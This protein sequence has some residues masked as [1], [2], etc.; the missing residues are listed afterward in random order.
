M[1]KCT[2]SFL[3]FTLSTSL[4]KKISALKKRLKTW[5]SVCMMFVY[6]WCVV[7]IMDSQ[8]FS[9]VLWNQVMSGIF[10]IMFQG[11][12][13][14]SQRTEAV[15]SQRHPHWGPGIKRTLQAELWVPGFLRMSSGWDSLLS[16]ELMWIY[17]YLSLY[18]CCSVIKSTSLPWHPFSLQDRSTWGYSPSVRCGQKY[19]LLL[20]DREAQQFYYLFYLKNI[21]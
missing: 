2:C 11:V 4:S 5:V 12:S 14:S 8:I 16:K 10:R 6:V 7:Q 21:G 1:L 18:G 17:M 13:L 9:H 3:W 15:Q 19:Y 20:Q